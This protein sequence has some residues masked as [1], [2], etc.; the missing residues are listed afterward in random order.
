MGDRRWKFFDLVS[1]EAVVRMENIIAKLHLPDFFPDLTNLH[2]RDWEYHLACPHLRFNV[3]AVLQKRLQNM[4]DIIAPDKVTTDHGEVITLPDRDGGG[5]SL[6]NRSTASMF[7]GEGSTDR[8]SVLGMWHA[9]YVAWTLQ[10]HKMVLLAS[11]VQR[12]MK[13]HP[14]YERRVW[15]LIFRVSR[16]KIVVGY[17]VNVCN[18]T[19]V[20]EYNNCECPYC[21]QARSM[22]LEYEFDIV[23]EDE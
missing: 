6:F 7:A 15:S 2:N 16:K 9:M 13:Q 18:H 20:V 17:V 10:S 3:E 23:E 5:S 4:M 21:V 12:I 19:A 1:H 14:L 11:P 8:L 22:S